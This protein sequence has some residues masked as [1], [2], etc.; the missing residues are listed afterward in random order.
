MSWA[1]GAN[2]V[3]N[4][5][6]TTVGSKVLSLRQA[7]LLAAL[8]EA[9][10][11][12]LASG[13]V[14]NTIRSGL[15]DVYLFSDTPILLVLGMLGSLLAAATWLLLATLY[16]WPVSTTHSIVGA[17]LGFGIVGA[18]WHA[19]SW[20]VVLAI[21]V[22]WVVSPLI[23]GAVANIIFKSIQFLILNHIRPLD[24]IKRYVPFY[25]FLVV[26][27]F[28]MVA[29]TAGVRS[30]GVTLPLSTSVIFAII[31]ASC[32]AILGR[33]SLRYFEVKK[34][35]G[36]LFMFSHVERMFGYLAIFTAAGM[37]FAHGS[38]DVANA[39]GPLASIITIISKGGNVSQSGPL[40]FWLVILGSIG[41]V[42]GLYMYGHRIIETV[43]SKI[44]HLTPTRSFAAQL[45][46]TAVVVTSS[47]FG[48]PVSTTQTLV[49][50]VLGVGMA[51]G[52]AALN[53]TVVRGIFLSWFVTLPAG[54]VLSI[55]YFYIF[56]TIFSWG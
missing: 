28:A 45:A 17:V 3:A 43:G 12:L 40:P 22:S 35:E 6:G 51:R 7:I 31:L 24:R 37:A 56:K 53:M 16:G 11:A 54:A 44:T 27:L 26:L 36:D 30:F 2:D 20:N 39:I 1:I 5:M 38:N 23:G 19:I 33:W 25:L 46:T 14:T 48:L 21:A 13:Q 29:F 55:F 15:F 42:M 10:G 50:A 52:I 9:L 4:A 34:K 41:I 47:G 32:V 8:F 49:G 18:G